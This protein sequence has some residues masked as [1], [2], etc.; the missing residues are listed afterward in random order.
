MGK[1]NKELFIKPNYAV[2]AV[3]KKVQQNESY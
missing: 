1:G 3:A 2:S